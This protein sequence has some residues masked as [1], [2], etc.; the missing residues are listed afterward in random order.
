MNSRILIAA[1][2]AM[3]TAACGDEFQARSTLADLRVLAIQAEPPEVGPGQDVVLT[4]R[5]FAPEG[6]SITRTSWK[7]CPLTAG[8]QAGYACLSPRCEFALEPAGNGQLTAN[9]SAMALSCALALAEQ[10][11]GDAPAGTPTEFPESVETVFTYTVESSSGHVRE[12]VVRVPLSLRALP[13]K[14]NTNP[15]IERVRIAGRAVEP[16]LLSLWVER[17]TELQVE[18]DVDPASLDRYVDA[19]GQERVEEPV[20]S[21]Y[22]SAGRFDGDR[23]AGQKG[24]LTWRAEELAPDTE[25]VRFYLVVRDLRGGQS[26]AGAYVVGLR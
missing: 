7:F 21:F 12:A 11:G 23:S 15:R 16:G 6:E 9:P 3:T 26:V 8:A 20:V 24:A 19:T 2:V 17:G 25:E 22:A 14:P 18:V 1:V 13:E 5:V 10:A 4:P